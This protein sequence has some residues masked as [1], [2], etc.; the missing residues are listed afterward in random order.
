M[1]VHAMAVPYLPLPVPHPSR[2]A[3][4]HSPPDSILSVL[5]CDILARNPV[6]MTI[7]NHFLP[8]SDSGHPSLT[9]DIESIFRSLLA[10]SGLIPKVSV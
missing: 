6:S 5:L 7:V 2:L 10:E 9:H 1:T 8:L 4:S 3:T